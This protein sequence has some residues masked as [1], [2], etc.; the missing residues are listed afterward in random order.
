MSSAWS[1]L[2]C[3]QVLSAVNAFV[4]VVDDLEGSTT[5]RQ[6]KGDVSRGLTEGVTLVKVNV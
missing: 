2:K 4:D 6:D 1:E 3:V 5:S